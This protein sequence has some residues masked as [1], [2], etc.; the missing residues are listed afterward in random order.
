[1]RAISMPTPELS[2]VLE[3]HF[4][5]NEFFTNTVLSKTY[6]MKCTP[7]VDDP[8]SFEGPEIYKSIGCPIEWNVGKNIT[9]KAVKKKDTTMKIFKTDS[10]F[11]FFSPPELK[12]GYSEENDKIEEY[13]ENDFEIGHFI[14]ERVVPRAVLYFTGE[15]DEDISSDNDT[16]SMDSNLRNFDDEEPENLDNLGVD[17]EGD[18]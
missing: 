6:L 4:A 12:E 7:D 5:P 9:E 11:N 14:K 2:F 17:G 1:M 3:F 16:E 8:F 18:N 15:I 10:F 13:L